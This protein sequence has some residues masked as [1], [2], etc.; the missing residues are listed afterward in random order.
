MSS[1][2]YSD[3]K[4]KANIALLEV[5]K[6]L[7]SSSVGEQSEA[8]VQLPSLIDQY[9]FPVLINNAYLKL[10]EVFRTGNNLLRL[11]V[12]KVIQLSKRHLNKLTNSDEFL[13][14]IN[15]VTH[16]NDAVA[17]AIVLRVFGCIAAIIAERKNVHHSIRRGLE[18]NDMVEV[19]A[20]IF[21]VNCFCQHS[22]SFSSAMCEKIADMVQGLSTPLEMKLKLISILG[23]M[24]HDLHSASQVENI[25]LFQICSTL[26]STSGSAA[27]HTTVVFL[28]L[29]GLCAYNTSNIDKTGCCYVGACF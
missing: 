21:A 1:T 10:A 2:T 15:A 8:I 24:H 19:E 4:Q 27:L 14:R 16:S 9:P 7:R 3:T 28:C 6:G 13:K 5:E 18:S 26:L 29:A 22:K 25:L 17:R 11:H 23:H 20:A 12:L